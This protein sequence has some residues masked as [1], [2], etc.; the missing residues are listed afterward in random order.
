[1]SIGA[2][3]VVGGQGSLISLRFGSRCVG[4]HWRLLTLSDNVSILC[5]YDVGGPPISSASG[6]AP[7]W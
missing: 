1:M 3:P 6:E 2:Y 7:V 5:T 4:H